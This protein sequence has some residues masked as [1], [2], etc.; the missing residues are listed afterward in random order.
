MKSLIKIVLILGLF[1]GVYSCQQDDSSTIAPPR[2]Y[3]EVY[4]EDI[5]KIEEFLDTHY[6]TIDGDFNTVF[7]KIPDGGS[8]VPVSDMPELEFKEVNLHDI[9]YKVYYLK[10]REGTGESPTRVE[11]TRVGLSP[12]PSLNFK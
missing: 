7:T 10:L 11:S 2:P 12:V 4:E 8:Q 9:T 6:V 3:N 5:L 1:I